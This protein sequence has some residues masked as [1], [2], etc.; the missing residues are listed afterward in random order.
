[1]LLPLIPFLFYRLLKRYVCL[2]SFISSGGFDGDY[3]DE[4]LE[5]EPSRGKWRL[6]GQ[7]M[8][9]REFHAISIISTEEINM[10]C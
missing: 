5:F 8:K 3:L 2:M 9:A 6:V 7:M 4:I 10:Y 1:M